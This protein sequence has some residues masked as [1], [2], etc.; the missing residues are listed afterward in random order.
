LAKIRQPEIS[1]VLS[2]PVIVREAGAG[3]REFMERELRHLRIPLKRLKIALEIPSPAA[4]KRLVA[5][6]LGIGYV[7]RIGVEQELA[8]WKLVR[9]NCPKL[10]IRRPFSLLLPQGP[11]RPGITQAFIQVLMEKRGRQ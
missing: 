10:T 5:A 4:I 2:R 8:A 9:I 6:G 1:D 3:S 7:F 11:S